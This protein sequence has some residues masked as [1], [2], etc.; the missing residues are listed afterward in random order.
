[1]KFMKWKSLVITCIVCLLP[2]LLG[3][4]LW[5]KLPD[6]MAIHFNLNNQPDNFA[7]KGFVVFGLPLLMT[8]L[9]VFCCFIND[10]N[11]YKHGERKKFTRVT[12][13]I[14]PIMAIILQ[15]AT[16]GYG[17]GWDIDI[18]RLAVFIVGVILLVIG[19]YLPKFEGAKIQNKN[20]EKARKIQRFIGFE[21]VV[22]GILF[23]L[24][25]LFPPVVSLFCLLLFVPY[26][27]TNTVYG[28][29]VGRGR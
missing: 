27:I 1:M 13:W 2:I 4:S 25:L 23:L 14:I 15:T 26:A 17:L 12:K 6:T 20:E 16:L 24:S 28:I 29:K 19:N 21:T 3:I 22:M 10:I 11:A 18:R 7:S 9:Q 5:S 8:A